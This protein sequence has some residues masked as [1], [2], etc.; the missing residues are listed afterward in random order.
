MR[1][2]VAVC[3]G[4]GSS[5]VHH[6]RSPTGARQSRQPRHLSVDSARQC[7]TPPTARSAHISTATT[8]VPCQVVSGMSSKSDAVLQLAAY[9]DR[10]VVECSVEQKLHRTCVVFFFSKM[11]E[12]LLCP[13]RDLQQHRVPISTTFPPRGGC[14]CPQYAS[15]AALGKCGI[16]PAFSPMLGGACPQRQHN[17]CSLVVWWRGG[18]H[19]M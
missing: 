18:V 9:P 16:T 8:C 11:A 5:T 2:G 14:R 17:C 4:R 19:H 10:L 6:D 7:P 13:S 1:G 12:A 3:C 15:V